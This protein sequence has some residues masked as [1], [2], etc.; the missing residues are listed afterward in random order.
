MVDLRKGIGR[1]VPGW[2]GSNVPPMIVRNVIVMGAQ[3]EDGMDEDAPSGVIRGYDAVTGKFLWAWD[4]GRPSVTTEPGPGETYT[5]GTP[6]MWTSAAGD[7]KLG[8]VYIPLG[9]SSVDYFG[10][11]RKDFENKYNSSVVAIDVTPASPE[12]K[13]RP[14]PTPG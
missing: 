9:N 10:G 6:N 3:V 12:G 11:N 1:T 8:L 4:M 7:D 14:M 2:Y 5:R 13:L